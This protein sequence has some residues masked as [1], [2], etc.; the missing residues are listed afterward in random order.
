MKNKNDNIW[1]FITNF[2]GDPF[3]RWF[4]ISFIFWNYDLF[5][6]LFFGAEKLKN[7]EILL[8]YKNIDYGFIG[9]IV[10][11]IKW[12]IERMFGSSITNFLLIPALF[13]AGWTFAWPMFVTLQHKISVK[14]KNEQKNIDNEL[15]IDDVV[16]KQRI[17]HINDK[18]FIDNILT[19]IRGML[20]CDISKDNYGVFLKNI[21]NI[22]N[23]TMIAEHDEY[24]KEYD[25]DKKSLD[26]KI[27]ELQKYENMC[28]IL[29]LDRDVLYR[30]IQEIIQKNL[31]DA[32]KNFDTNI[33]LKKYGFS[34]LDTI[35]NSKLFE[36][37]QDYKESIS[38]SFDHNNNEKSI[39]NEQNLYFIILFALYRRVKILS[40]QNIK[41]IIADKELSKVHIEPF[42]NYIAQK[43][44]FTEDIKTNTHIIAIIKNTKIEL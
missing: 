2:I 9:S 14:H 18:V 32:I 23:Y 13:S 16:R 12:L 42:C 4:I 24:R 15:F 43:I 28:N 26:K 10:G 20:E 39:Y 36:L 27:A 3:R 19:Q 29:G 37:S 6:L 11:S 1:L 33:D 31:N 17:N 30:K 41:N 7:L 38:K 35:E 5:V 8:W 25:K 40:I 34:I 22:E 21:I 44:V